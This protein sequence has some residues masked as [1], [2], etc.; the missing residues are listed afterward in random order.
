MRFAQPMLTVRRDYDLVHTGCLKRIVLFVGGENSLNLL[1]GQVKIGGY[2]IPVAVCYLLEVV[3]YFVC[4]QK[5]PAVEDRLRVSRDGI[6]FRP[7]V[8]CENHSIN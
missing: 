4:S 1:G 6:W 2:G 8:T 7:Y 5:D 3:S